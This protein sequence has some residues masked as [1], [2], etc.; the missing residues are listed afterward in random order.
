MSFFRVGKYS[1]WQKML[2]ASIPVVTSLLTWG[3][4][5]LNYV[6]NGDA[7]SY[8]IAQSI[9]MAAN[10]LV[11]MTVEQF[12]YEY[13]Q[14]KSQSKKKSLGF[15]VSYSVFTFVAG[16]VIFVITSLLCNLFDFLY[17]GDN[18]KNVSQIRFIFEI[19]GW[20]IPFFGLSH[21]LQQYFF[22][23]EDFISPYFLASA[24]NIGMMIPIFFATWFT[25][26]IAWVAYSFVA[27]VCIANVVTL[28]ILRKAFANINLGQYFLIKKVFW[29]SINIRSA[30]N[31][32]DV[33]LIL[34]T[35]IFASTLPPAM[36][37]VLLMVQRASEAIHSI[38]FGPAHKSIINLIGAY[39]SSDLWNEFFNRATKIV[40]KVV[41]CY[42]AIF[43]VISIVIFIIS[44]KYYHDESLMCFLIIHF[45]AFLLLFSLMTLATPSAQVL[46][47]SSSFKPF[48]IANVIFVALS[49]VL[50]YF[51][52]KVLG[53]YAFSVALVLAHLVNY[54]IICHYGDRLLKESA[55]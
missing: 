25:L 8:F 49:V 45:A 1:G 24:G 43:V 18:L 17:D 36:S 26:D 33:F 50:Y 40:L 14:L 11:L 52:Q 46:L 12:V 35:A 32:H 2:F 23:E 19:I 21:I 30:H 39:S 9:L 16:V 31:V 13:I 34:S 48:W 20:S 28:L 54:L 27:L 44:N 51:Q 47:Y 4:L 22:L 37:S 55:S 10:L 29:Q 42:M 5:Y 6:E 41:L 53:V 15:L 7:A 3:G 38:T